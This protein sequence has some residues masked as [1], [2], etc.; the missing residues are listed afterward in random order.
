MS[1]IKR[2]IQEKRDKTSR[3]RRKKVHEV[4]WRDIDDTTVR[5]LIELAE[6]F[7]GAIRFGRSRDRSVLSIGFYIGADRFTE[8]VPGGPDA[9]VEIDRIIAE[10]AEDYES[11]SIDD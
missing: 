6:H 11:D 10:I 7:D 3:R 2:Q 4:S 5:R 8:W 9:V 1:V